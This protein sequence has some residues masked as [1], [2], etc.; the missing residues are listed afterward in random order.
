M[1]RIISS[2]HCNTHV[3]YYLIR[4]SGCRISS[5][6]AQFFP[7]GSSDLFGSGLPRATLKAIEGMYLM[8]TGVPRA[9]ICRPPSPLTGLC[10]E[11]DRCRA[12]ELRRAARL[13]AL[14]NT[15]AIQYSAMPRKVIPRTSRGGEPDKQLKS[16]E[17]RE[18][19]AHRMVSDGKNLEDAGHQTFAKRTKRTP[20]NTRARSSSSR[21]P[22][23][24]RSGSSSGQ[25][26]AKKNKNK[27]WLAEAIL[28]ENDTQYL[29]E[30]KAVSE[31]KKRE[32]SWQPKHYANAAL[33]RDWEERKMSSAHKN[34][35]AERDNDPDL[36]WGDNGV[37]QRCGS[38]E[39]DDYLH[40]SGTDCRSPKR[41]V[42]ESG[43]LERHSVDLV[44]KRKSDRFENPLEDTLPKT[45]STILSK[46]SNIPMSQRDILVTRTHDHERHRGLHI[47]STMAT[48][49]SESASASPQFRI[50]AILSAAM[51]DN[52]CCDRSQTRDDVAPEVGSSKSQPKSHKFASPISNNLETSASSQLLRIADEENSVHA[53]VAHDTKAIESSPVKAATECVSQTRVDH[54]SGRAPNGLQINNYSRAEG[55]EQV[56]ESH[57]TRTGGQGSLPPRPGTSISTLLSTAPRT[58]S[59]DNKKD[60]ASATSAEKDSGEMLSSTS[61][62]AEVSKVSKCGASDAPQGRLASAKKQLQS[63]LRGSGRRR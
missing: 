61:S 53:P 23:K 30:Y 14:H 55:L 60:D 48:N 16:Y 10:A 5:D 15:F 18:R 38:V 40:D 2:R 4:P 59:N 57:V 11:A 19:T 35:N 26:W 1:S 6:L 13:T 27:L 20:P 29:I 24:R 37:S 33:A 49:S 54:M 17:L 44:N 31:G 32:I 51:E 43:N 39:Y 62:H 52:H 3:D 47:S 63:L 45:K 36:T 8:R 28:K 46:T 42:A 41:Y 58:L 25:G 7:S 9:D 56:P 22:V 21:G 50:S 12:P 34:N